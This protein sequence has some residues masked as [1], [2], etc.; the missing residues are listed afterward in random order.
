MQRC[1]SSSHVHHKEQC[2]G[3]VVQAAVQQDSRPHTE[4]SWNDPLAL[5]FHS[6][7]AVKRAKRPVPLI[8]V[9]VW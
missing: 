8:C 9:Q 2:N 1:G 6:P 7:V 5:L 4:A 3:A